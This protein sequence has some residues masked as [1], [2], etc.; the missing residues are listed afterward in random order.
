MSNVYLEAGYAWRDGARLNADPNAVGKEIAA[1]RDESGN[2]AVPA[3][4]DSA[5][6]A[7]SAMHPLF[8]W[9]D[10][11]AAQL[12]REDRARY[13]LRSI[14][15]VVVNTRT[16]EEEVLPRRLYVAAYRGSH[17][18]DDAGIYRAIP[19]VVGDPADAPALTPEQERGRDVLRRWADSYRDDPF[20]AR[21][22]AA[23][24]AL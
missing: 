5:R 9:D 19:L 1:L 17:D 18:M 14:V 11:R 7:A 13:I 21:V 23:I 4:V 24:D 6:E 16:E 20:F 8:E 10:A 3:V 12:Q 15:P 22:V 2:V